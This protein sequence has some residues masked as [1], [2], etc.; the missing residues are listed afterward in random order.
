MGKAENHV[1]SAKGEGAT[2]DEVFTPEYILDIIVRTFGPI[3]LDPCSHPESIVPSTTAI[4]LPKYYPSVAPRALRTYFGD[5]LQVQWRGHGLMFG[6]FPYSSPWFERFLS[7]VFIDR[8]YDETVLLVPW[9]T[10][11][12]Y[13]PKTAGKADVEVRLPRVKHHKAKTHAPFHSGLLYAGPRVELAL[14]LGVLGDVRVHPRH[15]RLIT[16]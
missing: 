5:G 12:V 13:W 4:M 3:G 15:T 14:G 11:N 9:R 8:D 1:R 16:S 10:G 7:K 6:N 2:N